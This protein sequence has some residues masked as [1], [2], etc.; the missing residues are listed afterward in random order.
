MLCHEAKGRRTCSW[1]MKPSTVLN[2][3]ER[4]SKRK[5]ILKTTCFKSFCYKDVT[6]NLDENSFSGD[7]GGS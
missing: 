5:I 7:M 3:T 4:S 6:G 1:E 2:A